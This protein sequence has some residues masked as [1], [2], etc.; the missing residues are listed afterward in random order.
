[1]LVWVAATLMLLPKRRVVLLVSPVL[2]LLLLFPKRRKAILA[3][4]ALA[5]YF[6]IVGR[7]GLTEPM[8][9][10]IGLA[11]VL[12]SS[13][14]YFLLAMRYRSL[15]SIVQRFPLAFAHF[16]TLLLIGILWWRRAGD[17]PFELAPWLVTA[18]VVMTFLMWRW[19]YLLFSGRRGHVEGTRFRDHIFYILPSFG[20]TGVP[21]GKGYDYLSRCAPGDR[22]ENSRSQL[23]GLKLLVLVILWRF[24]RR[25]IDVA[26]F[27][28]H[29][30]RIS[31]VLG[32]WDLGLLPLASQL[33]SEAPGDVSVPAGWAMILAA[34]FIH[35]LSLAANGHLIVGSLRLFGY[36]VFRNTY[37]PLLAESLVEYWNRF[38][39][40]FKELLVEFFFYPT[41]LACARLPATMR[42]FVS[43]MAAAFLGN[44]YYHFVRDTEFY[45]KTPGEDVVPML[46]PWIFYAFMLGSGIFVSMLRERKRR[47]CQPPDR[48]DA[49]RILVR[50]RRIL[51]VWLFYGFLLI[52]IAGPPSITFGK[53][54]EF[55][56]ALL[57]IH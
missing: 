47:R 34:L 42:I 55:L 18:L 48:S 44:F 7:R 53:R 37:K 3:L 33:A 9:L 11:L 2:A 35:V 22:L 29:N 38:Y 25:V 17:G 32:D 45:L 51:G 57:A 54:F 40:Y 10:M 31:Y 15:P 19:T 27:G 5:A 13:Y 49:T 36:N 14:C 6:T 21:Y 39:Y 1:M 26:A 30:A 46:L 52:W 50:V 23:A 56:L 12:A 43:I 8:P 24:V 16:P 4:G 20:G 41:F 28:S